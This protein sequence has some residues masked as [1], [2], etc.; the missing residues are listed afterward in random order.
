MKIQAA[1]RLL[2]STDESV[3][4]IAA[5]LGFSDPLYFS[6][7]F[8]RTQGLSPSAYRRSQQR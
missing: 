6:R 4:V 3:K 8:R 5:R 1:C 2:D 7:V